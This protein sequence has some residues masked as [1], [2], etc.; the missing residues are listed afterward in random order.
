MVSKLSLSSPFVAYFPELLHSYLECSSW[1]PTHDFPNMPWEFYCHSFLYV[2]SS[3]AVSLNQEGGGGDFAR[4]G[5]L[6]MSGDIFGFHNW[7]GQRCSRHLVG[8]AQRGCLT[9]YHTRDRPHNKEW[10]FPNVSSAEVEK[11]WPRAADCKWWHA[12]VSWRP[13]RTQSAGPRPQSFWLHRSGMGPK[14]VHSYR[15]PQWG[16]S[17]W[18]GTTGPPSR[19]RWPLLSPGLTIT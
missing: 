17:C 13:S 9:P 8:R 3:R 18:S 19:L 1:W 2:L 4:R 6:A 16:G 15:V 5:F 12:S 14:N 10:S 11:A 7:R